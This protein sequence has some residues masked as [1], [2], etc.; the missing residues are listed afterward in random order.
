MNIVAGHERRVLCP[1]KHVSSVYLDVAVGSMLC[2]ETVYCL[3]FLR[4]I[5]ERALNVGLDIS[6][7]MIK[8]GKEFGWRHA[9]LIVRNFI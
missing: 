4:N 2:H 7:E 1:M 6:F 8:T 5:R 9:N 3:L